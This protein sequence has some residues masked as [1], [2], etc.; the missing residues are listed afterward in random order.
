MSTGKQQC[1]LGLFLTYSFLILSPLCPALPC[2]ARAAH[3]RQTGVGVGW[4]VG[5]GWVEVHMCS[6]CDYLLEG[7][8]CISLAG[9]KVPW[10]GQKC[11]SVQSAFKHNISHEL[12]NNSEPERCGSHPHLQE[13]KQVLGGHKHSNNPNQGCSACPGAAPH[14]LCWP[15]WGRTAHY[16]GTKDKNC[17]KPRQLQAFCPLLIVNSNSSRIRL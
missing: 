13:R 4:G 3:L 2:P 7:L 8:I 1:L 9:H 14:D 15:R 16:I 5:G 17:S 10:F 12:H 11:Y 6:R